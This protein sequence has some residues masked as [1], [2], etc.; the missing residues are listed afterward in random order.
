MEPSRRL[1][2]ISLGA[3]DF[4]TR[5][6]FPDTLLSGKCH[7]MKANQTRSLRQAEDGKKKAFVFPFKKMYLKSNTVTQQEN[8]RTFEERDIING[9]KSD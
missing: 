4:V 7:H 3:A 9:I 8:F 5:G 2:F 6:V 1:F